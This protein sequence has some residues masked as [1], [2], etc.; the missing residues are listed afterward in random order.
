MSWDEGF[1][2]IALEMPSPSALGAKT[3]RYQGPAYNTQAGAATTP[4]RCGLGRT[5]TK[6]LTKAQPWLRGPHAKI[7]LT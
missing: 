5:V 4:S 3:L 2:T 7:C 6:P 1:T